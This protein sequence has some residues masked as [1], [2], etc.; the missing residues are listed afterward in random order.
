MSAQP[1][2]RDFTISCRRC[3]RR[4]IVTSAC[5]APELCDEC[6]WITLEKFWRVFTSG[7]SGVP[8]TPGN[9]WGRK[10]VNRAAPPR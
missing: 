10:P 7:Q 9:D 8:P 4:V 1:I 5:G 3:S 2:I 6:S